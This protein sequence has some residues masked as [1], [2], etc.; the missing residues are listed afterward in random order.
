MQLKKILAAMFT[1]NAHL[2][3]KGNDTLKFKIVKRFSKLSGMDT[4]ISKM[5][6]LPN[7]TCNVV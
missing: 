6:E 7:F 5:G 2:T 1:D 4:E 3:V